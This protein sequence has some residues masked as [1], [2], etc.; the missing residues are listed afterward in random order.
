MSLMLLQLSLYV[1]TVIQLTSS[2]STY[3]VTQQEN[4][5]SS[6]GHTEEVVDQLLS[7]VSQLQRVNSQ[8]TRDVAE[9]KAAIAYKDVTGKAV[10]TIAIRL[11]YD[12]DYHLRLRR[13]TGYKP[14][15]DA[16][17]YDGSDRNYD[18]RSQRWPWVQ[19]S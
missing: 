12:Y 19:I 9:M 18:M 6:C 17:D 2:Q 11:R 8:L 3:D 4:D 10:I 1:V 7:A 15:R 5:V 16:F 14:Y 13:D